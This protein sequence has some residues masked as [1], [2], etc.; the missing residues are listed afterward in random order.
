MSFGDISKKLMNIKLIIW[1]LDNTLWSGILSQA[2]PITLFQNR[3]N[4]VQKSINHG[5]VHS[6][7][8]KNDFE[9]TKLKLQE[10]NIWDLFIFPHI[11][12]TPK[13]EAIKEIIENMNLRP[14]NTLFIDDTTINLQEAKFVSPELNILN[15][16]DPN[17]DIILNNIL[18][19]IK[20]IQNN[21][22]EQYRILENK[23]TVKKDYSNEDFLIQSDIKLAVIR[24]HKNLEYIDRIHELINRSNQLNFTHSK[25][26]KEQLIEE[27]SD[28]NDNL[29]F[30]VFVWDKYGS[31]GLVGY[32]CVHKKE[33]LTHFV[34]SCRIMN[35]GVEQKM[36][37]WMK[38]S[39]PKIHLL[40]A[41]YADWIKIIDSNSDE[42]LDQLKKVHTPKE[43][44]IRVIANCSS[45]IIAHYLGQLEETDVDAWPDTFVLEKELE[46]KNKDYSNYKIIVYTVFN[47]YAHMYW[48]H[49]SLDRLSMAL[50]IVL[51]KWKHIK[52]FL[53]LASEHNFPGK[54][55]NRNLFLEDFIQYNQIVRDIA[56]Q[57]SN[58]TVLEMTNYVNDMEQCNPRHYARQAFKKVCNKILSLYSFYSLTKKI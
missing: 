12:F 18:E 44:T 19:S 38:K 50:T 22:I 15:A 21:R 1:D 41:Q 30:S 49:F 31:Y 3:I 55:E 8:S 56:F 4:F 16:T 14:I 57:Y 39:Y 46:N 52:V 40:E 36:F 53:L 42:F 27:I 26:E 37:N 25:V 5:L 33:T 35:M 6:I 17:T 2:E 20:D 11:Q 32:V 29:T 7:C 58:V 54:T 48:Q 45:G 47:D 34:F 24:N 43:K 51:E 10:L 13:G 23:H 28:S 9:T